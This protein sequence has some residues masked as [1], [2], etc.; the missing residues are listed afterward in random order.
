ML[1]RIPLNN[2]AQ[3]RPA[4]VVQQKRNE[5]SGRCFRKM[6]CNTSRTKDFWSGWRVF[7]VNRPCLG[8]LL[9]IFTQTLSLLQ[10]VSVAA[11]AMD[12]C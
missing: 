3:A 11:K 2:G 4:N 7:F 1:H 12:F 9:S 8:T 5:N 10:S 6:P